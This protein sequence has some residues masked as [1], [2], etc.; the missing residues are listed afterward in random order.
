MELLT[1]RMYTWVT[2]VGTGVGC[3][4]GSGVVGVGVGSGV[5]FGIGTEVGR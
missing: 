1:G 3:C 4:E 5:G 2:A